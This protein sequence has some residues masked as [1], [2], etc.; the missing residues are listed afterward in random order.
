MTTLFNDNI[1]TNNISQEELKEEEKNRQYIIKKQKIA[2]LSK[3]QSLEIQIDL[4]QGR[5]NELKDYGFGGFDYF[6]PITQSTIQET[7]IREIK[8]EIFELLEKID[9]LK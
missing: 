2:L 1:N 4:I 5:T 6:N 8:K 7:V 9:S 3:I